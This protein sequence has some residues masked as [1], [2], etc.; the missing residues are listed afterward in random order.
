MNLP[1]LDPYVQ[2]LFKHAEAVGFPLT[3]DMSAQ[4][5]VGYGLYDDAGL[6]QLEECLRRFPRLNILGHSPP[7]WSEVSVLSSPDER[8]G[9]PTGP[10]HG[11]GA[12]VRLLR[13]YPNLWGDLSATSGYNALA[14]DASFGVKF[15]NEFQDKLL[16]GMDIC[17]PTQHAP[18]PQ[19]LRDLLA[20]GKI[21][22]TVFDKIARLNAIRLL[23]L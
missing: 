11:E 10:V 8:G 6:P 16:F 12:T 1:L 15:L 4:L 7:F 19:F 5:G 2:N 13:K 23:G 17:T 3:V 18:L 9:Y 14:R 22:Q 20:E 21:S